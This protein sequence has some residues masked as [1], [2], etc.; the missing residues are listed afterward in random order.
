MSWPTEPQWQQA[1]AADIVQWTVYADVWSSW[2]PEA[3]KLNAQP[4]PIVSGSVTMD[5]TS[6]VRRQA[7]GVTMVSVP[8]F[9]LVP[10]TIGDVLFPDGAEM[11]IYKGIVYSGGGNEPYGSPY[12]PDISG[13]GF[14]GFTEGGQPPVIEASPWPR[15][16]NAFKFNATIGSGINCGVVTQPSGTAGTPDASGNGFTGTIEGSTPP[17]LVSSPWS[18]FDNA[19]SFNGTTGSGINCG[20]VPA[21]TGDIWT[22]EGRIVFPDVS[23]GT[24]YVMGWE[25]SSFNGV[26]LFCDQSTSN[27]AFYIEG[28]TIGWGIYDGIAHST[29]DILDIAVSANGTTAWIYING[30]MAGTYTPLGGTASDLLAGTDLWLGAGCTRTALAG[31]DQ[32]A[33]ILDEVRVSSVDRYG[34]TDYMPAIVPFTTDAD[35]VGLWHLDTFTT[36]TS[37]TLE[38]KIQIGAESHVSV[39]AGWYSADGTRF[40]ALMLYPQSDGGPC[41]VYFNADP[42]G[43]SLSN[44]PTLL[45]VGTNHDLAVSSDGTTAWLYVDGA[46]VGSEP[47]TGDAGLLDE[48]NFWIGNADYDSGGGSLASAGIIDEVRWSDVDRYGGEDYAPALTPFGVGIAYPGTVGLWPLDVLIQ[49]ERYIPPNQ[50]IVPLGRL[51][52]E[53]VVVDD[54][55]QNLT[56]TADGY[57]RMETLSRN[58]FNQAGGVWGTANLL[59]PIGSTDT[60][61]LINN[62]LTGPLP[63]G[64][65]A[66]IEAETIFV[67]GVNAGIELDCIRGYNGTTAVSH[68][69]GTAIQTTADVTIAG[70]LQQQMPGV[71][72]NFQLPSEYTI[73]TVGPVANTTYAIGDDPSALITEIAA[74]YGMECYVDQLGT[75]L[76]ASIPDQLTIPNYAEYVEGP[77]CTV[78]D[79]QRTLTN[80]GVPNWI[81]VLS[82]GSGVSSG[83]VAPNAFR[84]DWQD[85]N[86][87]SPTFIDGNY[88]TTVQTITTSLATT[89]EATDAMASALGL[90]NL[91][92]FDQIQLTYLGDPAIDVLDNF[93]VTRNAID[94][95]G[96][97]YYVLKGE[98]QLKQGDLST[99]NGY[100]VYPAYE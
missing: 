83:G 54:T 82:Q 66:Y 61:F 51:L 90:T 37:W 13:N 19:A 79:I 3:T 76:L 75:F 12:T 49:P 99:L 63:A 31:I 14:N 27:V 91:G 92:Q 9:D 7:S 30:V 58:Q 38:C 21:L 34:G 33:S 53:N 72:M 45:E 39:V 84:S 93:T 98:C 65:L 40:F 20:V 42:L 60:L 77:T 59:A 89:Q 10:G 1:L 62:G 64:F 86:P 48:D 44:V 6:A 43:I 24:Q 55:G 17:T 23:G 95:N 73:F 36:A 11:V 80:S 8:G 69:V 56:I 29:G 71:P 15:F 94:L 57:D 18:G 28:V 35:T 67:T 41:Y 100:R 22:L 96:A 2:K 26:G 50:D 46:V 74:V 97:Q 25:D 81:I 47:V 68:L 70:I 16:D 87:Y 5:A 52:M 85:T 78:T 88:P 4:V 32:F